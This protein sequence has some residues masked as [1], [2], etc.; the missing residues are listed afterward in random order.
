MHFE[1]YHWFRDII[2][3]Q[4]PEL[5]SVD[6]IL[7]CGSLDINGSLQALFNYRE[8]ITVDWRCGRGVGYVSLVHEY[9][10]KPDG[11]FDIVIST[12]MFEHDPYW[13]KSLTRM[14]ELLRPDGS[15]MVTMAIEDRDPHELD[16]SPRSNYYENIDTE[17]FMA[18]LENKA[19]FELLV[20]SIAR[21]EQDFLLL[22]KNKN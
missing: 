4:Y 1:I 10:E 5:F 14:L 15:M 11:Y 6:R 19:K 18:F 22:G 16:C 2:K 12:E 3:K 8:Y 17:E 7:E 21:E 13:Q 9:R 20:S